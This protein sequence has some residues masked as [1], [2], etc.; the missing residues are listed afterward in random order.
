M[1]LQIQSHILLNLNT[2]QK[3]SQYCLKLMKGIDYKVECSMLTTIEGEELYLKK[4]KVQSGTH[5]LTFI[6][7]GIPAQVGIDPYYYLIDKDP[8]DNVI[9]IS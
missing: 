2:I 5:E 4:H 7:N 9:S 3:K 1:F 8:N 6:V